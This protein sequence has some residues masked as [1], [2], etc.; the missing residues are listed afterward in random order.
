[1]HACKDTLEKQCEKL[2]C[3]NADLREHIKLLNVEIEQLRDKLQVCCVCVCLCIACFQ[4]ERIQ[5]MRMYRG[6]SVRYNRGRERQSG[7]A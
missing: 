2:S 5:R 6:H 4:A 3:G 7:W 1:M